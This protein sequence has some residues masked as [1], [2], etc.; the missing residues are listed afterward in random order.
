[1][2][3]LF[4]AAAIPVIRTLESEAEF[5]SERVARLQRSPATLSYSSSS[6]TN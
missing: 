1:M 2:S 4:A 5:P 3:S 6:L